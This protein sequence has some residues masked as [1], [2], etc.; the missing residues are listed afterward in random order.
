MAGATGFVG[1]AAAQAI[2]L[3]PPV[4][5]GVPFLTPRLSSLWVRF[6]TRANWQVA[7]QIVVGLA[8]D[9]LSRDDRFWTLVGH[10]DRLRFAEAAKRALEMERREGSVPGAWG[11][12]ERAL[13]TAK[14]RVGA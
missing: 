10:P 2:G 4:M 14:A 12:F 7:R 9:L 8:E 13:K 1:R 11:A 5:I 3:A 6:V